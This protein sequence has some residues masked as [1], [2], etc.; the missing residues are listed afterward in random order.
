[1][2]RHATCEKIV[3]DEYFLEE[4]TAGSKDDTLSRVHQLFRCI[5]AD[6]DLVFIGDMNSSKPRLHHFTIKASVPF[7]NLV[8]AIS[9]P[10]EY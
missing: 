5:K 9:S 4:Y 1:M 6:S 3:D 7:F 2:L 8:Q 10:A